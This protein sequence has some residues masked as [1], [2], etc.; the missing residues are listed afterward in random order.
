MR[1]LSTLLPVFLAVLFPFGCADTEIV[2]E[3]EGS[4]EL[5]QSFQVTGTA[6]GTPRQPAVLTPEGIVILHHDDRLV[7]DAATLY[8]LETREEKRTY[9]VYIFSQI[10]NQQAVAISPDGKSLAVAATF[11][12]YGSGVAVWDIDQPLIDPSPMQGP[13][14]EEISCLRYNGDGTRLA[15]GGPFGV[16]LWE[17]GPARRKYVLEKPYFSSVTAVEFSPT[18]DTILSSPPG[19]W[20]IPEKR[21]VEDFSQT[22]GRFMGGAF[23]DGGRKVIA[24]GKDL[25]LFERDRQEP[26]GTLHHYSIADSFG[27]QE[28]TS[29]HINCV[30]AS[31]DGTLMA[32]ADFGGGVRIYRTDNGA[33]VAAETVSQEITGLDFSLFDSRLLVGWTSSGAIHVWRIHQ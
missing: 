31:P 24:G 11:Q 20:N 7:T 32:A 30:A 28:M 5:L 13:E 9:Q 27:E 18:G 17:M 1:P 15:L 23:I 4:L 8:D 2:L 6:S 16:I 25:V 14:K 33:L 21:L 29:D 26:L 10:F 12:G 19:Y 22:R 3:P